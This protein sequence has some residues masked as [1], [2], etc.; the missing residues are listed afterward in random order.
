VPSEN[1]IVRRLCFRI[2]V[3]WLTAVMLKHNLRLPVASADERP[4]PTAAL[5]HLDDEPPP[6]RLGHRPANDLPS[7]ADEELGTP[8]QQAL[9][10]ALS[11]D[12]YVHRADE[13]ACAGCSMLIRSHA[14]CSNTAHYGGYWVGGGVPCRRDQPYADE[15]TFGWD[16][17]GVLFPKRVALNW[18]HGRRF[19]GGAG[20]YRTDG[21][22]LK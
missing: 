6:L 19:Q 15:G 8:Q 13:H 4:V 12:P 9:L 11:A 1:Q 3:F 7:L 10:M 18:S 20:A 21:P 22:K 2:T 14:I 17:F 5:A 16:Y